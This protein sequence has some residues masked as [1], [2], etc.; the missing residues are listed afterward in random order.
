MLRVPHDFVFLPCGTLTLELILIPL[1]PSVL[2][3]Y[4]ESITPSLLRSTY[5]GNLPRLRLG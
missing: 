2:L 4:R 1:L 3:G 5:T